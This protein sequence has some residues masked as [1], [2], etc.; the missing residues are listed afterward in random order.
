MK[1]GQQTP[2]VFLY[3]HITP[4]S[5]HCND[6]TKT[7]GACLILRLC[8]TM[9]RQLLLG[10]NNRCHMFLS[11]AIWNH[12]Q[13]IAMIWG[14]QPAHAWHWSYVKPCSAHCHEVRTIAAAC[15]FIRPYKNHAQTIAMTLRQQPAHVWYLAYITPYS[16]HLHGSV[17]YEPFSDHCQEMRTTAAAYFFIR[18]YKTMPSKT[19]AGA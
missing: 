3:G 2:H 9:L 5:G 12:A 4:C 18:P 15:F 13:T 14:Q 16:D 1:W 6:I 17:Y 11:T 8:K 10:E 19:T 7:A